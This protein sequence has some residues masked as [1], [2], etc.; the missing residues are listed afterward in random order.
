[1][2]RTCD[3]FSKGPGVLV[4]YDFGPKS[5]SALNEAIKIAKYINGDIHLLTVIRKGDFF[6][7]LFS[8][9]KEVRRL[10]RE[11]SDALKEIGRKIKLDHD[12]CPFIIVE[13]GIPSE[14]ILE[15]AEI[16][17]AEYIVM[18]KVSE[19]NSKFNFV[20]PQTLH[21]ITQSPC[22]VITVAE[23]TVS[24][25]GFK[26]IL[27]PIDLTKQSLE[28]VVKSIA[29]AKYYDAKI[30][31]VGVLT[32]GIKRSNSRINAK[33]ERAKAIIEEEGIICTARLYDNPEE[34]LE[35]IIFQ[36]TKIVNGDLIMIM[37]HQEVGVLDN[38][39]GA[40]AQKILKHAEIPVVS[41]NSTAITNRADFISAFLPVDLFKNKDLKKL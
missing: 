15:Q 41:F 38:Y 36:H 3:E 34:S 11:A 1:M 22:P 2:A 9:D 4:P 27:L 21:V 24:E 5:V 26:N 7:N 40:V 39:I 25:T 6:S 18:G 16:I 28:K 19:K 32:G 31:L 33:L 20:G 23:S 30:H 12:I 35:E 14:V 29:W 37:T 17:K 8:N 10:I 13:K